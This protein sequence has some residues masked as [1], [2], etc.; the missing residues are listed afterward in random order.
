MFFVDAGGARD[1]V[2]YGIDHTPE[3]RGTLVVRDGNLT[4]S[5]SSGGFR[6]VIIVTG[7]GVDTGSCDGGEGFVV[8][9]GDMTIRLSVSPSTVSLTSRPNLYGVRLWSWRELYE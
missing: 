7:D 4:I 6:G 9:S 3:A 1:F 8:A 2:E 5:D